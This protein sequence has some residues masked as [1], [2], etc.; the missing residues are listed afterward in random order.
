MPCTTLGRI[1]R[2][3]PMVTAIRTF[4]IETP[5]AAT[6][7]SENRSITPRATFRTPTMCGSNLSPICRVRSLITPFVRF[8][9][10]AKSSCV[11]VASPCASFVSFR[12]IRYR[13]KIFSISVRLAN[14]LFRPAVHD[15]CWIRDSEIAIPYCLTALW[16][17]MR[18]EVILRITSRSTFSLNDATS[19]P[20]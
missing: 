8:N 14:D 17:P 11:R 5:M 10:F 1:I 12:I 6:S 18:A 7:I 19:T 13:K 3:A 15:S 2:N 20:N 9:W 16:L 4:D